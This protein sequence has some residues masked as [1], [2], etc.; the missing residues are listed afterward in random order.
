MLGGGAFAKVFS[1]KNEATGDLQALKRMDRTKIMKEFGLSEAETIKMIELEFRHLQHTDHP[2]IVRLLECRQDTRYSYFVMEAANG[3]DLKK[4]VDW[5]YG[6]DRNRPESSALTASRKLSEGYVAEVVR[7]VCHALHHLHS[8]SRIHKDLK[9]EN[10]MLLS[11]TGPPHLVLIDLGMMEIMP[12]EEE[13]GKGPI[14]AGTPVTMAPEV[15]DTYLGRRPGGFDQRCDIYSLGVVAFEMLTGRQP[16]EEPLVGGKGS[17]TD[18]EGLR[19]LIENMD[20]ETMLVNDNGRSIEA[21][22]LV[23]RMLAVEPEKRPQAQEILRDPWLVRHAERL[24]L[25]QKKQGHGGPDA[26]TQQGQRPDPRRAEISEA[27]LKF[28]K[29]SARQRSATYY[30]AGHMPLSKLGSAAES[31][32]KI[33]EDLKEEFEFEDFCKALALHMGLDGVCARYV[34]SAADVDGSGFV[35][36]Q[37][38]AQACA[39]LCLG[40]ERVLLDSVAQVLA[41]GGESGLSIDEVQGAL[42]RFTGRSVPRTEVAS[43]LASKGLDVDGDVRITEGAFREHVGVIPAADEPPDSLADAQ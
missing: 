19:Q 4:I 5:S 9:L 34:A 2:N 12:E 20:V 24:R 33:S 15:I 11:P 42:E 21:A 10:V 27:V 41:K 32:A 30:L 40:R 13:G 22:E 31:F 28:S 26:A 39:S 17:E 37:D 29:R 16:Y 43:W 18:Y 3:G 36:F 38:F 6:P 14:P 25:R 23:S 8:D 1:V 35:D 7:Q